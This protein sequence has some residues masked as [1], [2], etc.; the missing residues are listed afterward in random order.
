MYTRSEITIDRSS[1]H[2]G[3]MPDFWS[4]G[5]ISKAECLSKQRTFFLAWR[6]WAPLILARFGNVAFIVGPQRGFS[7][8]RAI[9]VPHQTDLATFGCYEHFMEYRKG[10]LRWIA[11]PSGRLM[12][13]RST[14]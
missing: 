13:L 5:T 3:A 10:D 7:S 14:A 12:I 4:F 2:G 9:S 6:R 1:N 11:M 8:K